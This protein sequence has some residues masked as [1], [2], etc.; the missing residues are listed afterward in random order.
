[1]SKYQWV[2]GRAR[3]NEVRMNEAEIARDRRAP[4]PH[5]RAAPAHARRGV[6]D[7]VDPRDLRGRGLCLRGGRAARHRHRGPALLRPR[8]RRADRGVHRQGP[9]DLRGQQTAARVLVRRG[10]A[11]DPHRR[12][13]VHRRTARRQGQ[14]RQPQRQQPAEGRRLTHPHRPRIARPAPRHQRRGAGRR[15]RG[16]GVGGRGGAGVRGPGPPVGHRGRRRPQPGRTAALGGRQPAHLRPRL[17]SPVR[18]PTPRHHVRG[19]RPG[20][21]ARRRPLRRCADRRDLARRPRPRVPGRSAA[22]TPLSAGLRG[23]GSAGRGRDDCS[24]TRCA[25]TPTCGGR[26]ATASGSTCRRS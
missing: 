15:R 10:Q 8:R 7:P 11:P 23:P 4:G 25:A 26:C 14:A 6:E 9:H 21:L 13:A 2:T 3:T 20:P 19:R 18:H 1:M 22:R 17:L 16:P 5:Q 12:A 24:S